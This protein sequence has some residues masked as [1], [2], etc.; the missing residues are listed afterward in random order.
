MTIFSQLDRLN[1]RIDEEQSHHAEISS[2]SALKQDNIHRLI[3]NHA[4]SGTQLAEV[5]GKNKV[6]LKPYIADAIERG[7]ISEVKKTANQYLY[8]LG[9]VHAL[10]DDLK[11]PTYKERYKKECEIIIIQSLKGGTG[12]STTSAN[13]ASANALD[14]RDRKRVL[15]ID[16][17]PQGSLGEAMNIDLNV[18]AE[19]L[20]AVDMMLGGI[21]DNKD[22][23][24]EE[25]IASGYEHKNIVKD[26][27]IKTHIPNLDFIPCFP[28]ADRFVSEAWYALQ[29]GK[30]DIDF[31]TLLK[32]RVIAPIKDDYDM[33]FIDTPPQLNPLVWAA[34]EAA[35]GILIPCT[36][37]VLDWRATRVM[38]K[39]MGFSLSRLPSKGE[40]V[41]W[42][43]V[44]AVNYEDSYARDEAILNRMKDA[45]GS[46]LLNSQIKRSDAFEKAAQNNCTVLDIV[47]EKLTT[48]TQMNRAVMSLRDVMRDLNMFLK[49]NR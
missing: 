46:T 36:P 23:L 29:T 8:T 13:L 24:Y 26:G 14:L 28:D 33:I 31:I 21:E 27:I 42:M 7:V 35:T 18:D 34:M 45:L 43:K 20:T 32:E 30:K 39:N 19:F 16:L 25:L 9:H 49:E 12:K 37:H 1:V 4:R 15:L 38:I 6:S 41:D 47:K 2:K 5:L 40:N 3:F 22:S 44:V 48:P 11:I 10:M 17:D